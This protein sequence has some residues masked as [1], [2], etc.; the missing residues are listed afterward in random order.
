MTFDKKLAVS[1][2]FIRITVFLVLLMW[3]LDKFLNPGHVAAIA[4][5]FYFISGITSSIAYVIASLEMVLIIG[6]LLGLFK[7]WT[8]GLV[9]LV[10]AA[11]TLSPIRQYFSPYEGSHLLFFA[12]WP[13]LAACLTLYLLREHDTMLTLKFGEA[14][15][16]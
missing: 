12:A 6:F 8:Y 7:R 16:A 9:L 1:L 5:K 14:E 2:F 3:T 10:H 13:M 4:E 15:S 11:S